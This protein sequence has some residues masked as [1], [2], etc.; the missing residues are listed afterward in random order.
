MN[1]KQIAT[2]I[3]VSPSTIS[4]KL[5]R[6]SNGLQ[7]RFQDILLNMRYLSLMK[8]LTVSFE[9]INGMAEI[10]TRIAVIG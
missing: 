5:K 4:R 10:C 3:K 6:K 9:M 7:S 8:A 1:K 2:A